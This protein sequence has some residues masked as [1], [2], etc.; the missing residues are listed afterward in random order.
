MKSLAPVLP[1]IRNHHEKWDGSGYPD[2]L[3]GEQTPLLARILQVADVY[4]ALTSE[5][6]YK[7]AY[8][9]QEA[10]ALLKQEVAKGWRDPALVELFEELCNRASI[11]KPGM[12]AP[13][14]WP[15][16]SPLQIS[17]HNMSRALLTQQP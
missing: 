8:S 12:V 17:L 7:R 16:A 3:V 11:P 15:D 10:M 14:E 9:H 13:P 1:I 5:R 6:S 2:G 4:D